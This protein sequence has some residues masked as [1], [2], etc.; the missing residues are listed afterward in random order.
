MQQ[1][2]RAPGNDLQSFG[3][4]LRS[5]IDATNAV[6]KLN[7]LVN[8]DTEATPVQ[9]QAIKLAIDKC[10]PSLAAILVE[11]KDDRPKSI[12]DLNADLL[13]AGVSTLPDMQLIDSV[14]DSDS[15]T[16]E[17]ETGAPRNDTT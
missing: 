14:G 8:G 15:A 1:V 7:S 5:R 16:E 6:I 11:V 10:L 12:H 17:S 3:T 9:F 4:M 2:D 13:M